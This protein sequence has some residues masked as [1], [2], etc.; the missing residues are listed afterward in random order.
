M[1]RNYSEY[2]FY[3]NKKPIANKKMQP[4]KEKGAEVNP[5]VHFE[6]IWRSSIIGLLWLITKATKIGRYNVW[7][8]FHLMTIS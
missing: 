1:F 8:S 3:I 6:I 4:K 5:R 2:Q 7:K